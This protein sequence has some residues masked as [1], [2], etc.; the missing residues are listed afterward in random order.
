MNFKPWLTTARP[1]TLPLS[2]A[3]ILTGSILGY[4]KSHHFNILIFIFSILTTILLQILSNF[5][6]D[7]G[8]FKKQSDTQA[9]LGPKRGIQNGTITHTQLKKAIILISILSLISGCILLYISQLNL[10]AYI[11]FGIIGLASIIAAITYTIGK[12]PYGYMAL[13]DLSVFIFFG[14]VAVCGSSYLQFQYLNLGT[15]IIGIASGLLGISVLNINNLRDVDQDKGVNK[16]TIVVY[17]GKTFAKYY[18]TL[19]II[20]AFIL[21]FIFY[22]IYIQKLTGLL[23]IIAIPEAI[24]LIRK[25]WVYKDPKE[26]NPVLG[27]TAS[28]ILFLNILFSI[29]LILNI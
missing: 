22:L 26:L 4:Y 25:V 3:F 15:L 10:K 24:K 19:L 6:N 13:G 28:M 12:K 16:N 11:S 23:F 14:L 5:A 9:R 18:Y 8:D 1:K 29:G 20:T 27:K 2:L 21:Y 7:Y 17:L